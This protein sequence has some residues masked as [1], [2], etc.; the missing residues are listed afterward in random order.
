M[1]IKSCVALSLVVIGIVFIFDTRPCLASIRRELR[2]T[3]DDIVKEAKT[4]IDVWDLKQKEIF[5][6]RRTI[7]PTRLP[8]SIVEEREQPSS[9]ST[10][11]LLVIGEQVDKLME[12]EQL[13]PE[14]IDAIRKSLDDVRG[15]ISSEIDHLKYR[16]LN[17]NLDL[18]EV[19]FKLR[20]EYNEIM[21]SCE[22]TVDEL[23]GNY[24]RLDGNT[25]EIV[26]WGFSFW[27]YIS[28][29]SFI[30]SVIALFGCIRRLS[31]AKLDRELKRLEIAEKRAKL[32]QGGIDPEKYFYANGR[33]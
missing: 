9:E 22:S 33:T 26:F 12:K 24:S 13:K 28:S 27:S 15:D 1:K 7:E 31:N 32:E 23:N 17:G 29:G 16:N 14:E 30:A 4:R 19:I 11:R 6:Q 5:K 3:Q 8:A 18:I 20:D 2:N 10:S 21:E 25:G